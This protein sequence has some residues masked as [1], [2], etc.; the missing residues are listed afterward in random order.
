M[1][2]ESN[3]PAASDGVVPKVCGSDVELGNF[4]IGTD[5]TLAQDTCGEAARALLAQVQGHSRPTA[6]SSSALGSSYWHSNPYGQSGED[7]R[8]E[9]YGAV[10]PY[11]YRQHAQDYGRKFLPA[12][13]GCVYIDLNHLE[14]CTPECQS[15]FD[16]LAASRAMLWIARD[17][18]NRAN[19]RMPTGSTIKVLA[20]NSD[21]RGNSYG[22]HLNFLITRKCFNNILHRKMHYLQFLA[23]FQA[24]AIVLTGAG[25]VGSENGMNPV[26]YQ[27]SSR[28][29]FMETMVS[30]ATTYRRPLVN[31]RDESLTGV[32]EAENRK[33]ARLHVIM[34]DHPL[35][36]H[37]ALL[38]VGMMQ[39]I[40]CMIEQEQVPAGL[41]LDD[42]VSAIHRW[43]RDPKLTAK[44]PLVNGRHCS[45]IEL[46][47]QIYDRVRRFVDAGRANGLVPR[48]QE[49][50]S[51]WGECLDK[52][53]HHDMDYLASRIDWVAK[54]YLLERAAANR[55]GW[56]AVRLKYLDN[57]WSSLDPGEGLYWTLEKAGAVKRLATESEIER[58]VHGP[59][60]D[61][62]AWLRV[63][64]LRYAA[65]A[66]DDVDWDTIRLRTEGSTVFG[67]PNYSSLSM[68]DPLGF[69]RARCQSALEFASS[70]AEGLRNLLSPQPVSSFSGPKSATSVTA[71]DVNA[72]WPLRQPT[73]AALQLPIKQKEFEHGNTAKNTSD[74]YR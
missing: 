41:L 61:T 69:T 62:R 12:N 7:W 28:A 59:P 38:R 34:F 40:L 39:V 31:A 8:G 58:F 47:Q 74:P 43:S 30:Q 54:Q 17:A 22:S 20:N 53:A 24:A 71:I 21:G 6:F 19:Q 56:D 37:A 55:G 51:I 1:F 46:L 72:N 29:D 4:I 42:P 35:C 15:A 25:K 66:V 9:S 65:E 57:I 18:M 13:G 50:M 63:W 14:V 2:E 23:S 11:G 16:H 32:L 33:L 5:H 68:S 10:E 26:K 27:I 45:A 64:A 67:W 3:Q 49:I 44:A 73:S 36:H 48:V 70:P 52:L 60:D